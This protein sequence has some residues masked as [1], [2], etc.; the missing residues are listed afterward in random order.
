M[1]AVFTDITCSSTNLGSMNVTSPT[2]AADLAKES[3]QS[4]VASYQQFGE[5]KYI[6][7]QLR[8]KEIKH[9]SHAINNIS[10]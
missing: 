10:L 2:S 1:D 8:E 7:N 4:N 9:S 6:L 3:K 5:D